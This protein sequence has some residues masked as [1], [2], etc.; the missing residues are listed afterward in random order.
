MSQYSLSI[1]ENSSSSND[2]FNVLRFDEKNAQNSSNMIND[3]ALSKAP[4][5]VNS[6]INSCF[7]WEFFSN[8]LEFE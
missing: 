3:N 7:G 5:N 1:P 4:N 2:Y 8:E 6:F